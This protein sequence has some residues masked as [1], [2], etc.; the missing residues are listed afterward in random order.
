VKDWNREMNIQVA[1]VYRVELSA[2]AAEFGDARRNLPTGK[3]SQG[4]Q[5]RNDRESAEYRALHNVPH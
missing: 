4:Q 1:Q 3:N 2:D 5:Q